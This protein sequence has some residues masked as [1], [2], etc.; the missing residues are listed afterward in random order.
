[1]ADTP[2]FVVLGADA[3]LAARPAT[4]IQMAH[5]CRAAGFDVAIPAT[6]GDELIALDCARRLVDR[7]IPAAVFCACERVY[8]HLAAPGPELTP[9]LI[10]TVAPPIATARY[11]RELYGGAPL[12]IT[13]VGD[14]PSA[15]DASIDR[16]IAPATF[17]GDLA[18]R[19]IDPS[20]EATVFQAVFAPDRRRCYSLP[21]GLPT[22]ELLQ[23]LN[24]AGRTVGA[25]EPL[26]ARCTIEITGEEYAAE[27]VLLDLAPRLGCVCSGAVG[28]TQ[29]GRARSAV[30]ALEPPRSPHP[31][32]ET[33]VIVDLAVPGDDRDAG[34]S[35]GS[36]VDNGAHERGSRS[37]AL[38]V[39]SAEVAASNR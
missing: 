27:L 29:P 21:G 14:C 4:P 34:A 15:R 13:Y 17:L 24:P 18:Q 9:Y 12:D 35:E 39:V 2:S 19:G 5:A 30:V 31:I 16:Q 25:V 1:V 37:D 33:S 10:R 6:W 23:G 38:A 3:Y 20:N 28:T 36:P 26:V 11:L 7:T 32:V 22:D 8:D